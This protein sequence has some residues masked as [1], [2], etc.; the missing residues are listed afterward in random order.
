MSNKSNDPA[1]KK[2]KNLCLN[3]FGYLLSEFGFHEDDTPLGEFDNEFQIRFIRH[4]LTIFIEGIHYGSSTM[5][6]IQDKKHREISPIL[7]KPD[8]QP[9]LGKRPKPKVTS[10]E[11]EMKKEARLLLQ[12]GTELLKGDFSV[13]ERAF[14]KTRKA[15]AGYESRRQH[16][17]S[18]QKAV[19]AFRNHDWGK[20]IKLLEPYEDK[21]S[22]KMTKKL[23]TARE[24]FRA[25]ETSSE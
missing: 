14:E 4:D 2:F 6:Y 16:G 18:V 3:E 15:W 8:F 21:M 9:S 13:F 25:E 19:D 24:N 22:K 23:N 12:Y 20:V 5:I 7:L 17:V 1:I 10:Q 11:E